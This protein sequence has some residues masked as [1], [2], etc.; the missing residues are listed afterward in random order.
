LHCSLAGA[1]VCAS[2]GATAAHAGWVLQP[3][4]DC[5]LPGYA[6]RIVAGRSASQITCAGLSPRACW[7]DNVLAVF[8]RRSVHTCRCVCVS[9]QCLVT[10]LHKHCN[11]G[12]PAWLVGWSMRSLQL[13]M[14]V[15]PCPV[16]M[17]SS[18]GWCSCFTRAHG[19]VGQS[20]QFKSVWIHVGECR[21]KPAA[22]QDACPAGE[23]SFHFGYTLQ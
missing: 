22:G 10:G 13:C 14:L 8:H 1:R 20:F 5:P 21:V 9:A 18:D 3:V 19:A 4:S 12:S 11:G 16:A 6:C 2:C 15:C 17:H 23:I 7:D